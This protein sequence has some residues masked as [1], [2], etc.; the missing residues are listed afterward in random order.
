M[1]IKNSLKNSGV[2]V[3]RNGCGYS[4]LRTRKLAVSQGGI[5]GINYFCGVDKNLGKPE[6][7]L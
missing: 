6:V 4:G 1:E 7:S 5:H 2:G 3:F